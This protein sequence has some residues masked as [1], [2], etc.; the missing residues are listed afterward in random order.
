MNFQT[1][2]SWKTFFFLDISLY[3]NSWT[4]SRKGF[5]E[6]II[7]FFK[8]Q[9][10]GHHI[11]VSNLLIKYDHLKKVTLKETF[12]CLLPNFSGPKKHVFLTGVNNC[13][14]KPTTLKNLRQTS[15]S[16]DS[17][18]S[19]STWPLLF[20]FDCSIRFDCELKSSR[21]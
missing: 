17:D 21:A 20:A 13:K 2:N 5:Y 16:L 10:K 15:I 18:M 8:W 12:Q 4:S 6:P 1:W 11:T 3:Q 19:S 9:K 14:I 7:F